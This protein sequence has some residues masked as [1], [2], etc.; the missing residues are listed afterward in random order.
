MANRI[1]ETAGKFCLRISAEKIKFMQI[2]GPNS[3]P[4]TLNANL[5]EDIRKFTYLRSVICDDGSVEADIGK[6]QEH[7]TSYHRF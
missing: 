5:L 3:P 7:S 4:I 2:E 6:L 1:E